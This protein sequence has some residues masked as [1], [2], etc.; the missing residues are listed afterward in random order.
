MIDFRFLN[1]GNKQN[2]EIKLSNPLNDLSGASEL[3][4]YLFSIPLIN[5]I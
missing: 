3:S 4:K 2:N 5:L 1:L